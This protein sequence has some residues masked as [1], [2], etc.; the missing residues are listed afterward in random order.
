MGAPL[1]ELGHK[2]LPSSKGPKQKVVGLS[3]SH[4]LPQPQTFLFISIME[5]LL[6]TDL[7]NDDMNLIAVSLNISTFLKWVGMDLQVV[8]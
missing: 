8:I 2:V 5:L 6:S 7:L 1:L 4:H 3:E